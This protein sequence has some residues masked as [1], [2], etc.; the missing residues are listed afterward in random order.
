MATVATQR[1]TAEEFWEWA[2]RPE[3]QDRLF[4]LDRGE[5]MEMPPP[6]DAHGSICAWIA[7]LLWEYVLRRGNGRVTSNDTGLL[8]GRDPDSVR[9]PDLML[10]AESAP[11]ETLSKGFSEAV[12]L[13]IIE[14]W[15][16]NDRWSR[17]LRRI[18]QYTRRGVPL[19]WVVDPE[20]R[21]A[22]VF[23]PGENQQILEESAE[24]TGN[25]VLA[26]LRLRVADLF[27]L[28]GTAAPAQPRNS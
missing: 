2:N 23:R 4:E 11:L 18:D 8:V 17:M 3:N 9:G 27:A 25:G 19:I 15:S 21:T 10:F 20:E 14:V 22:T 28:P 13:L 6:G 1:M 12:P 26:D 7:H 24:L 5:V 16:P